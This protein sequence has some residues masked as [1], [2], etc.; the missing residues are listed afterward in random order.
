M[1]KKET[2]KKTRDFLNT[3]RTNLSLINEGH[4]TISDI[5]T[6]MEVS[7]AR[8]GAAHSL[9]LFEVKDRN[10]SR[11][12]YRCN[13]PYINETM[14]EEVI[15]CEY[16]AAARQKRALGRMELSDEERSRIPKGV[17]AFNESLLNNI[18]KWLRDN[19][20]EGIIYRHAA[21]GGNVKVVL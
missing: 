20:F 17:A 6:A 11:A 5:A 14:A 21:D 18:T 19:K 13:V 9:R 8:F 4:A 15:R 1:I 16:D 3:V 12:L 2:I 10:G 7:K